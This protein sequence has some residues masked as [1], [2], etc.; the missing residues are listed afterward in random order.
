M[1]PVVSRHR[2]P[3]PGIRGSADGSFLCSNRAAYEVRGRASAIGRYG[4]SHYSGWFFDRAGSRDHS[5]TSPSVSHPL[6]CRASVLALHVLANPC[7]GLRE[8]SNQATSLCGDLSRHRSC[9]AAHAAAP[10]RRQYHI[11]Y[12]AAHRVLLYM[13]WLILVADYARHPIKPLRFVATLVVI[14][15]VLRH[16]PQRHATKPESKFPSSATLNELDW[17]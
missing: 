17:S 4:D 2:K 11:L 14:A 15:V 13:I 7:C 16:L 8:T 5:A 9:S 10:L 3:D 12:R 6:S 1:A